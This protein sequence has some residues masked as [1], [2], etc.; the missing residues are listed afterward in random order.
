MKTALYLAGLIVITIICGYVAEQTSS[1]IHETGHL[2]GGLL[3]GYRRGFIR[4]GRLRIAFGD[5]KPSVTLGDG[6][7][8]QC[9]MAPEDHVGKAGLL[10]HILGGVVLQSILGFFSVMPLFTRLAEMIRDYRMGGPVFSFE[11]IDWSLIATIYFGILGIRMILGAYLNLVGS[12]RCDGSTAFE[13]IATKAGAECIRR[14]FNILV[15]TEDGSTL[16]DDYE[17]AALK[18]SV[19]DSILVEELAF[20]E[21]VS[22]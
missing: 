12:E 8:W 14:I 19:K 4:F 7:H 9:V 3:A 21:M 11:S 20:L 17:S 18:L 22:Q 6:C 15:I 10:A 16:G 1:F 13:V 2:I 5:G